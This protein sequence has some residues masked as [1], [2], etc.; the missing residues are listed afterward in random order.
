ME[1]KERFRLIVFSGYGKHNS[2]EFGGELT[3]WRLANA[4]RNVWQMN[5]G[6]PKREYLDFINS[7]IESNPRRRND[8][9]VKKY[10]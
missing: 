4:M 6:I 1:K 2:Y 7:P 3:E 8:K 10:K 9:F 5:F